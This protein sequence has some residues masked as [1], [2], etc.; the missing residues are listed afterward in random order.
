MNL[1]DQ[2][3]RDE[4]EVLHAYQDSLGFW[5]IGVGVLIDQRKGGGIT[6]DESAML[7][8]NRV[9]AMRQQLRS[10]LPWLDG[11]DSIRQ[12]ALLNMAYQLGVNGVMGFPRMLEALRDERWATAEAEGL[13]SAWAK[14]QTPPRARRVMRQIATG[15]WQ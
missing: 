7:L 3:R 11:L 2:L 13:D 4:G 8:S 5:T 9:E 1:I 10:K 6:A 14:S 12:A 15:E